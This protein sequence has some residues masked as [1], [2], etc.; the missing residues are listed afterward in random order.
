MRKKLI[1]LAPI[2]TG[3]TTF[4][5]QLDKESA[6]CGEWLSSSNYWKKGIK[7]GATGASVP[8]SHPLYKSW[9]DI[10][11]IGVDLFYLGKWE[12]MIY[13]CCSHISYLRD[14]YSEVNLKIVMP[15]KEEHYNR[16]LNRIKNTKECHLSFIQLIENRSSLINSMW[17]WDY[18]MKERAEYTRLANVFGVKIYK[19][20]KEA[21]EQ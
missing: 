19:S 10:Y 3:K 11:K 21:Y 4:L 20:F 7:M 14:T 18:I 15:S 8:T 16:Y 6:V 12:S 5:N 13:N 9:D 2:S 17:N 1:I